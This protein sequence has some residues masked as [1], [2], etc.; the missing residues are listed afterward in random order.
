MTLEHSSNADT[1]ALASLVLGA[2][3][4]LAAQTIREKSKPVLPALA[5]DVAIKKLLNA[6]LIQK[7]GSGGFELVTYAVADVKK[8][9]GANAATLVCTPI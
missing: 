7:N 4:A 1:V 8:R 2:D 5:F 6:Q 3:C 9:L